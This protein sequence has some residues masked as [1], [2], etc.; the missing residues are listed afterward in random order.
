MNHHHPTPTQPPT[1][2][3]THTHAAP[4]P[5]WARKG[6][7]EAALDAGR[8]LAV[9]VAA[10][11]APGAPGAAGAL[12]GLSLL[13]AWRE[14]QVARILRCVCVGGGSWGKYQPKLNQTKL[15]R[16]EHRGCTAKQWGRGWGWASG[17]V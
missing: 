9:G 10:A 13:G 6:L 5:Q 17:W 8:R 7:L 1:Y 15:N 16:A 14:Q 3:Y 12:P 2:P 4:L 11:G